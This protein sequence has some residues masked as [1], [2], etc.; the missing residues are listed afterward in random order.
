MGGF[1]PPLLGGLLNDST[2]PFDFD[3]MHFFSLF[4]IDVFIYAIFFAR[5]ASEI[6]IFAIAFFFN[7][8]ASAN[9]I[10][11]TPAGGICMGGATIGAAWRG[12]ISPH[13]EGW[14]VRGGGG[15]CEGR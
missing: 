11:C 14:G 13:L 2:R 15:Q 5:S 4:Q 3:L 6:F 12:Y 8:R 7:A 9:A 10:L 1:P